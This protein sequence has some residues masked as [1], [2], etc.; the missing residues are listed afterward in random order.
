MKKPSLLL[1]LLPVLLLI[2][3]IV[4]GS[5]LFNGDMTEGPAQVALI[6]AATV[7]SLI[8]IYALKVPWENIATPMVPIVV[9]ELPIISEIR[10]VNMNMVMRNIE[11][12]I[13]LRP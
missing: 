1:S 9:Q 5:F 13:N 3:V 7:G 10:A 2:A 4:L 8:A 6:L 11:G 12:R